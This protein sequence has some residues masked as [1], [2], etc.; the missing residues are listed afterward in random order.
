MSQIVV[1]SEYV[2][3]L[4]RLSS[5]YAKIS[6]TSIAAETD[7]PGFLFVDVTVSNGCVF[8]D[9]ILVDVSPVNSFGVNALASETVILEGT[10]VTLSAT[11]VGNYNYTWSP[12]AGMS[13]P[14]G[15]QTTIQVNETTTFCPSEISATSPSSI[16]NSTLNKSLAS[17]SALLDHITENFSDLLAQLEWVSLG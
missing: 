3:A 10:T 15:Q 1:K 5:G 4:Q 7:Q 9:S 8:T 14:N 16:S 2:K 12:N 6:P 11:P 17:F 13:N